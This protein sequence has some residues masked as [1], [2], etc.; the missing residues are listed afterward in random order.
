[1]SSNLLNVREKGSSNS[2][3]RD[4]EKGADSCQQA[5]GRHVLQFAPDSIISPIHFC[6]LLTFRRSHVHN[7]ILPHKV[8]K[9]GGS[10]CIQTPGRM[11]DIVLKATS[12]HLPPTSYHLDS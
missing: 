9:L 1:V 7:S 4:V 8:S 2:N 11:L 3:S 5:G 10:K 12:H 6:P